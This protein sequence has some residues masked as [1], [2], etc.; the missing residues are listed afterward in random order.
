MQNIC[1]KSV[2]GYNNSIHFKFYTKYVQYIKY[3]NMNTLNYTRKQNFKKI[4]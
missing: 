2:K 4:C 3:I 1:R